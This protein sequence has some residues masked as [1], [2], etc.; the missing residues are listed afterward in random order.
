MTTSKVNPNTTNHHDIQHRISSSK[1]TMTNCF[2]QSVDANSIVK[3][4]P[5][6]RASKPESGS[7]DVHTAPL[8][9]EGM[10]ITSSINR[11]HRT[12][13]GGT[14]D[15]IHEDADEESTAIRA[16]MTKNKTP[17]ERIHES[18]SPTNN[19]AVRPQ[20]QAM[21]DHYHL[22]TK[23]HK[24]RN[25]TAG[26]YHQELDETNLY[27]WRLFMYILTI[28]ILAFVIYRFLLT[29]WPKPKRTLMEQFVD[30]LFSFF[31]P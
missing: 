19:S 9:N 15:Y 31:T 25:R 17:T 11:K 30:D 13:H 21:G 12:R 26:K 28:V 27:R 10:K 29:V 18:S 4:H 5:S 14:G 2:D 20:Q 6:S 16:I 24:S 8:T 7:E 23:Q 1:R 22:N 3:V